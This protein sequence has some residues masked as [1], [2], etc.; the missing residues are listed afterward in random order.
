M[1][2]WSLNLQYGVAG[3]MNFA[4]IFF[5]AVGAY[6][7]AVLTLGP[8]ADSGFQS[9][10]GGLA[11][12]WPLPLLGAIIAGCVAA[13]L[14]GL[15]A[16]RPERR[17][18]QA[19]L[20]LVVSII[21]T[22]IISTETGIFNGTDGIAAVPKPFS[23]ALGL[24]LLDYAWF[25]VGLTAAIAAASYLV[26]HRLIASP[27]GRRLRAIR[28]NPD[29]AAALG[30][31]VKQQLMR[32]YVVGG[33]LAALSGGVLVLFVGAWSPGSWTY[34]E[35]FLLF[36]AI[37]V[38]GL[39]NSFGVAVGAAVVLGGLLESVRF[40]PAF[41]AAGVSESIQWIVLGVVLLAF[42]WFRPQGLVPERRRRPARDPSLRTRAVASAG[43]RT[44]R[45]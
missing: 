25:Y 2:A 35:T 30:V 10:V 22:T 14:V 28:D 21:A 8:A 16:L 9:Y 19:V 42:L 17:D 36:T 24:G 13:Y 29:A 41:G 40:L 5:Q 44:T 38:G 12:P 27:W 45:G 39:G 33:G 26:V 34:P 4:F 32:V 6:T 3:I 1:A 31:N 23:D 11:L 20:M 15:V 37:V 18:Y 7:A 43:T